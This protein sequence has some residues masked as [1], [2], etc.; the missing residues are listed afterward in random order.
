MHSPMTKPSS[1]CAPKA[2]FGPV[3][4]LLVKADLVSLHGLLLPHARELIGIREL[5]RLM[6]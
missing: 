5:A 1:T 4:A 2:D 3:D 6:E